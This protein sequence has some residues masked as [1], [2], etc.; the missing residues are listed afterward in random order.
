MIRSLSFENLQNTEPSKPENP[1]LPTGPYWDDIIINYQNELDLSFAKEHNKIIAINAFPFENM[2]HLKFER[3]QGSD[4]G[5]YVF[6]KNLK[7]T[8][9]TSTGANG[10][11]FVSFLSYYE[12][13]PLRIMTHKTVDLVSFY[14]NEFFE[15]LDKQLKRLEKQDFSVLNLMFLGNIYALLDHLPRFLGMFK[16]EEPSKTVVLLVS[17]LQQTEFKNRWKESM[18]CK[19]IQFGV[20]EK[21]YMEDERRDKGDV[22]LQRDISTGTLREEQ[23]LKDIAGKLRSGE[24]S[25]LHIVW[26]C[27]VFASDYFPGI[28][29]KL[30]IF[31]IM[32][33]LSF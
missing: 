14:K 10:N 13:H 22:L 29:L 21:F 12:C 9:L 25:S 31:R 20:D 18:P 23:L 28:M 24:Y 30:I 6:Q 16:T 32:S 8:Y 4:L 27:E 11:L 1:T 26:D 2:K 3:R 19:F 7:N 17:P 33:I 5:G 15:D